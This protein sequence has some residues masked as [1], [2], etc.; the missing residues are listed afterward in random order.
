MAARD[1]IPSTALTLCVCAT[2]AAAH[3]LP[4]GRAT[5]LVRVPQDERHALLKAAESGA[6]LVSLPAPGFAVL[7]GDAARIRAHLG[8]S[9]LWQGAAPCATVH[10]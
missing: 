9:V 6:A 10:S 5:V 7:R 2:I 4:L 1:L 8:L 3:V